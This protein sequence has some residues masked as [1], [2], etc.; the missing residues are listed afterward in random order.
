MSARRSMIVLT[1]VV[2]VAALIVG[3][4]GLQPVNASQPNLPSAN[5]LEL[6]NVRDYAAA[7]AAAPE[8]ANWA[9]DGGELYSGYPRDWQRVAVPQGVIVGAVALDAD[10]PQ[11]VY[12]GAANEM[13]IYRST[14][15]GQTWQRVPLTDEYIGGVTDLAVDG[16]HNLIYVGTDTAGIFRLRDVGSSVISGG[17]TM[18]YEQVV[19]VATDSTGS[20]LA[21]ARTPNNLYRA[22][23]GGLDWSR[24]TSLSSTPTALAVSD[25]LPPTV[26]VGTVDRGLLKSSDGIAWM[27]ANDGLGLVPG[28]RLMVDALTV[29]PQQPG[30]MYVATS[31][32]YGSTSL[33]QSPA[34]VA[35]SVDG[36]RLWNKLS[37][38]GESPVAEL[39]PLA[40]TT[41]AVYALTVQ[42]RT[43]LALGS[44]PAAPALATAQD[45]G[46]AG[47][48][49]QAGSFVAWIVAMAAAIW[50]TILVAADLRR[51]RTAQPQPAVQT[52]RAEGGD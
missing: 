40:G 52:V 35:M 47:L 5:K 22:E 39:L 50:L 46:S 3:V 21:F 15:A 30:V 31:Y 37:D 33:H 42:S 28:S 45:A 7:P 32:L 38:A 13:A 26:Y 2:L 51:V 1:A 34:G 44:A 36:G 19:E 23:N 11:T 48:G 20:A 14:N 10:S 12:I 9:V 43:P 29:D 16:H 25:G 27:N 4:S 24:V 17:H 41:G 18:I 49:S 8:A 6:E